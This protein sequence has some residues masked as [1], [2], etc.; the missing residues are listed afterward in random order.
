MSNH[1]HEVPADA[2]KG[3]GTPSARVVGM[4]CSM[5]DIRWV[6]LDHCFLISFRQVLC[7]TFCLFPFSHDLQKEYIIE[8]HQ[9]FFQIQIS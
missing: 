4:C 9:F 7:L 5:V 6:Y 3:A 2:G 8:N 1:A